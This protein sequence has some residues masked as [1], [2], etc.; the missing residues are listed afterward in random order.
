MLLGQMLVVA[1]A[2]MKR[3]DAG[4]LQAVRGILEAR[5]LKSARNI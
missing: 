5:G 1:L 3:F 4:M 2:A